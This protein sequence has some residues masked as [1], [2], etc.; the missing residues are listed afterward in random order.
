MKKF[1]LHQA[2]GVAD[3]GPFLNRIIRK[4]NYCT[5]VRMYASK[6]SHFVEIIR[7]RQYG[8]GLS[9]QIVFTICTEN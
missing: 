7:R 9:P 8:N 6:S 3:P 1:P 2:R 5:Y 4:C